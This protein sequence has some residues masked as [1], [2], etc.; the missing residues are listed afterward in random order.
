VAEV[1]L[2][3]AY[4]SPNVF[5]SESFYDEP[6]RIFAGWTREQFVPIDSALSEAYDKQNYR[7]ATDEAGLRAILSERRLDLDSYRDP[8]GVN[9]RTSFSISE[10]KNVVTF[11][12]AGPDKT[13]DTD[14]DFTAFTRGFE[15]FTPTGKQM[16]AGVKAYF[17]R[18]GDHLR[19]EKAVLDA[20]GVRE[21]R[22]RWG[23]PYRMVFET[24]GRWMKIIVRSAGPDGKYSE[25]GYG[26]DFN[27]WQTSVDY[28]EPIEKRIRAAQEKVKTAP[29]DEAEFRAQLLAADVNFDELRD[30]A[31]KPL[32][33]TALRT[34]RYWDKVKLENVQKHGE[35]G[36]VERRTVT[37]VTQEIM[38]F[39][40]RGNG[41]DGNRGNWD[42]VNLMQV[43]HVLSEQ[44]KDDP[45]PVPVTKPVS[46][47]R[48]TGAI[49]GTVTDSAGAVIPGA[50][51][52]ATND[53]TKIARETETNADGN[54]LIAGLQA[55]TYTLKFTREAFNN[56]V[57]SAVSVSANSTTQANAVL[58]IG[59]V[60]AMVEVTAGADVTV[61]GT[62][63][64]VSTTVTVD[65][66]TELPKGSNFQSLLKIA[67]GV[68]AEGLEGGFA[69]NGASGSEQVFTID[70]KDYVKDST[71]KLVPY[72]PR[73]TPRLREYF[74]ETLLWSPE[75]VTDKDG[76]A[77]MRFRMADNITTWKMYTI[78]ST[79]DGKIG[80]AEKE[81][82]AFQSFFVDLDPP[83]FLTDGDEIHLPTQV[84][85][86]TDAKQKVDVTMAK[87]DWFSFLDADKKQAEVAS[88]ETQNAVFGFKAAMP[89]KD[90]RQR[91]TAMAETDSDAIE[92]PVTVRPDGR[93]VVATDSRYFTGSERIDVNFPAN[94]LA[95]A[96]SAS[97]KIYPNLMAHVAE[98]VEGLLMRPYGCGEQ[99]ISSTYPNLMILKF[100]GDGSTRRIN[101]AT[102]RKA[103][104]YLQSGYDRLL[105]YQNTDGGFMYWGGRGSS[106]LA[107]TAYALRFLADAAE[108]AT[109]DPDVVKKAE[110]YLVSQQ[111]GDGSW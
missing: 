83:K 31:G 9:Y 103:R 85:N 88:G 20:M 37:P 7:H 44:S 58:E 39:T 82:A 100:A 79:K 94:S 96:R 72:Q 97:L 69:I 57:I 25:R 104:K 93:E 27:V 78:A 6:S 10:N 71:G 47:K 13:F 33:V 106:D 21:L 110:A 108:F 43:V 105:G 102:E 55:G 62:S 87:A 16:D 15:Y 70:G 74:P 67:P 3:D 12:S 54:Y 77:S 109:V 63:S 34:S 2:H 73:A 29:M 4:Y 50:K 75:I 49:A 22:D 89:I 101:A 32:Y 51:V 41:R 23:K 107:L 84:R 45:Q 91:V 14:D 19:S 59:G 99:T 76:K 46:Y 17:E 92:K 24:E 5:R 35:T 64:S 1:M 95:N 52:T 42:D 61:N 65:R 66:I 30:G 53:V 48:N 80:T 81:V 111:R 28:F 36:Y 56:T 68:Q 60:S 26:D 11:T 98:S 8:W 86:Y 18:T 40:I 90:G 38:L